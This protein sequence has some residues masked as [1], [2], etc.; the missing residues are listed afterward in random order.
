MIGALLL[1]MTIA[2]AVAAIGCI[3]LRAPR[4]AEMLNLAASVV[5]F[6]AA[7]PLDR[8][9]RGRAFTTIWADTSSSTSPAHG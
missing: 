2:P 4:V 9:E 6:V 3:L 8:P 7:I 5:V 1:V